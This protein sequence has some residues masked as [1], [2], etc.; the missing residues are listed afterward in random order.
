MT[1]KILLTDGLEENGQVILRQSADVVDQPGITA[2][3]LLQVVKD[4][5][6]VIVRGRTKVTPAVFA[7]APGLKVVGRSGVGVDNIDLAAAREHQVT[8]VNAPIAT[9]IAVAE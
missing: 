3:Q 2:E 9:T 4:Y 8:V 6:A 1:W 7:A 5:D